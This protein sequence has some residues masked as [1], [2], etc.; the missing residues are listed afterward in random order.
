MTEA[1]DPIRLAMSAEGIGRRVAACRPHA[2]VRVGLLLNPRARRIASR[3]QRERLRR[4]LGE[5]D[6]IEQPDDLASLRRAIARLLCVRRANVLAIAGGDG[7]LHHAVNA[8]LELTREA[9]VATGVAAAMPRILILNGGTLNIVGRTVAI[10]GQP[11]HTLARFLRY[12]DGAPLSRVPARRLPMMAVRW[13]DSPPRHGF[14][15][16]SETVYHAMELYMRFGA[17]YGGL[18]RF[19]LELGRGVLVGSELWRREQWKL[20]PHHEDLLID[21]G[22]YNPYVAVAASTV[23]L[24]LAIAAVRAIRRPL[25]APGFHAKVVVEQRPRH[26]LRMLPSVMT[27]RVPQGLIDIP[28]A[29]TMRLVG[30]YTLDGE[31]FNEPALAARRLPLSVEIAAERLH[32]VPGELGATEW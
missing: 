31:L 19:L 12:F 1:V 9:A 23:D 7:T 11:H 5:R 4:L 20:A 25:L 18:S 10:H 32:A 2:T 13:G 3:G 17:G 22:C 29:A 15:F 8:L 6:A 24:T 28:N 27:E 30:P 21:G 16:G 26:L 14:V